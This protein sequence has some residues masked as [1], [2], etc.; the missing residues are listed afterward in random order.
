MTA[1]ALLETSRWLRLAEEH[2]ERVR[3]WAAAFRDRRARGSSHPVH[4]FLFRYYRHSPGKLEEWHPGVGTALRDSP[5]ARERFT[6]P[7]YIRDGGWI[8]PDPRI[9]RRKERLRLL[10]IRDLLKATSRRPSNL[11]CFGMHEWAMV[12]RGEDVRHRETVPLRLSQ[13]DV[14]ALVESRSIVCSHYDAFRFFSPAARPMNLVTPTL[15]RRQELEQPGC[16]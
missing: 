4:D 10:R 9:L 8:A 12:Y 14:D 16:V 5:Q 2:R 6:P 1:P 3:P 11:A 7:R 13:K 15:S